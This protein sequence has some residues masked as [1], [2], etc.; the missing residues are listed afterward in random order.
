MRPVSL[1]DH[2]PG[3]PKKSLA[4]G[5]LPLLHLFPHLLITPFQVNVDAA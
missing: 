1:H 2:A 5:W 3:I 4:R